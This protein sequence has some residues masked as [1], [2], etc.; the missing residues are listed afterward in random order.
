MIRSAP[1]APFKTTF[2]TFLVAAV[3]A[4][5]VAQSAD[6]RHANWKLSVT[7]DYVS[8]GTTNG[9]CFPDPVQTPPSPVTAITTRKITLRTVRPTSIQ[10]YEAPNGVPATIRV[11]RP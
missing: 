3:V 6:A 4:L 9:E 1:P 10:M 7:I 8:T 2:I 11:S 5:V